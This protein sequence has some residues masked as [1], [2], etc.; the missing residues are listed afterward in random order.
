VLSGDLGVTGNSYHVVIA[1]KIFD[2]TTLLDGLTISGGN[3]VSEDAFLTIDGLDIIYMPAIAR[4]GGGMYNRNSTLHLNN[5]ILKNNSALAGGGMF[6]YSSSPILTSVTISGCTANGG[7]GIL[8]TVNSQPLIIGGSFSGNQGNGIEQYNMTPSYRPIII[9]AKLG[10]NTSYGIT[11]SAYTPNSFILINCTVTGNYRGVESAGDKVY[12][13]IISGNSGFN[14]SAGVNPVNTQV[15]TMVENPGNWRDYY[16]LN[17]DNA[18]LKTDGLFASGQDLYTVYNALF[19]SLSPTERV[20]YL[21][22]PES[23]GAR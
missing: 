18:T 21:A 9:N 7:A 23:M 4:G 5:V 1:V 14:I 13:S 22:N 20:E 3:C 11:S 16:P 6:N 19:S 2:K 8:N 17:P 15:G 12:N 10:N